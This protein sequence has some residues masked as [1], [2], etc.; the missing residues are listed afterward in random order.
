MGVSDPILKLLSPV[1]LPQFTL[2]DGRLHLC[3]TYKVAV[4]YLLILH[5]PIASTYLFLCICMWVYMCVRAIFA[6]PYACRRRNYSKS[7]SH[8]LKLLAVLYKCVRRNFYIYRIQQKGKDQMG[9]VREEIM[10]FS[11]Y[12]RVVFLIS[13]DNFRSRADWTML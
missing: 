8:W 7:L 10:S 4:T 3:A 6:E 9:W 1:L 5:I 13:S 11:L 2:D 12:L